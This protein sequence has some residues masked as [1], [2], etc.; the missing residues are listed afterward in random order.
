MTQSK[1]ESKSRVNTPGAIVPLSRPWRDREYADH[2]ETAFVCVRR[3]RESGNTTR[4]KQLVE[5]VYS[6]DYSNTE[7]QRI[8]RFVNDCDYFSVETS[9]KY[10]LIEPTLAVFGLPLESDVSVTQKQQTA[11]GLE[12]D[13]SEDKITDNLDSET[14]EDTTEYYPKDR[15]ES[16]LDKILRIN[17][18]GHGDYRHEI[19]TQLSQYRNNISGTYSILE[20]RVR[21][22]YLGVPNTT[23]FTDSHDAS[24]SQRR[25]RDA[26]DNAS[27]AFD[28]GVVV[29]LTIDP[30]RFETHSEA[31]EAIQDEKRTLLSRLSYQLGD[32][33]T[34]I[35]IPDFQTN[36]GLL[37]YHIA[38][39]G[40]TNVP[41]SQNETGEP[42]ISESQIREYWSEDY[43][44]GSQIS[45]QQ[46]WT[47]D[48]TWLL[49]R[50]DKKVS[51]SYYLGKRIRELQDLAGLDTGSIPLKYWR[52][53]LFWTHGIQYVS[54]SNSLKDATEDSDTGLS[55]LPKT[56]EW[57]YIGTAR[58]DQIPSQIRDNMIL[59][60]TPS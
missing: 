30:K 6:A 11:T 45:I 38:L 24:N 36:T 7:Y 42:T 50:D 19:L 52:H 27:E 28:S 2:Y 1:S 16:L 40:I 56:T 17:A 34:Q 58:F 43:D 23:R 35:T 18:D 21:E 13:N 44:I 37:H 32:S 49:H 33:P 20:H 14:P 31:T 41:E 59:V 46:T 47:R 29:T 15:V 25:F 9:G 39:F 3:N 5:Y 55:G 26:L 22:Q 60:G 4:L 53:A 54:C 57:E 51:L 10:T 48:G 12:K 8:R